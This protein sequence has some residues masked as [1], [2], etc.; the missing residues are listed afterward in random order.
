M[1]NNGSCNFFQHMVV[2]GS[3][4]GTGSGCFGI[5]QVIV[6]INYKCVEVYTYSINLFLLFLIVLVTG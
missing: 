5:P 6:V 1:R 3:A 4:M 2:C